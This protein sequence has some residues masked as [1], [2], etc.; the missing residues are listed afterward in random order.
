MTSDPHNLKRFLEAQQPIYAQVI[1]EL[2]AG[3]KQSHWMWFIFPQISGLGLSPTAKKY[4][5]QSA[6]EARAYLAHPVLGPRLR[7]CAQLVN[8]IHGRSIDEIFGY[9]D[10]LKFHSCMTLFA[11]LSKEDSV[12]AAAIDNYFN[13]D[14]DRK[15]LHQLR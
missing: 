11:H 1:A 14:K 6:D 9:P 3:Q 5:I 2:R 12:F 4:A 13:G 8:A 10:N 7:D 15:T